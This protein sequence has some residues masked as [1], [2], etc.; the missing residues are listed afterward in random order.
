[1]KK[2]LAILLLGAFSA[3]AQTQSEMTA[4]AAA[5]FKKADA[6]LNVVYKKLRATLDGEG[7]AKLK[8]A[9][10]AWLAYRDAQAALDADASRGGSIAPMEYAMSR[11]ASTEARTTAL[12]AML[13]G[14][15]R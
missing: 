4:E 15:V 7:Q 10:K 11:T 5:D 8:A 13:D 12:R 3:V 14:P 2:I 9:Q 6:A 1:M